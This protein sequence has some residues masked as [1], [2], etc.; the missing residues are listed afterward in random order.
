MWGITV[1][2]KVWLIRTVHGSYW[3]TVPTAHLFPSG[4]LRMLSNKGNF[5]GSTVLLNATPCSRNIYQQE[6]AKIRHQKDSNEIWMERWED[7]PSVQ[8]SICRSVAQRRS[9]SGSIR[10][11]HPADKVQLDISCASFWMSRDG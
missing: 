2:Y 3:Q 11:W 8:H 4:S 9:A 7:S 6:N 10:V 5:P 1:Q